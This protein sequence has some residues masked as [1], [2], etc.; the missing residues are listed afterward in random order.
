LRHKSANR[1]TQSCESAEWRRAYLSDADDKHAEEE[2]ACDPKGQ[3]VPQRAKCTSPIKADF[4]AVGENASLQ[5]CEADG[6]AQS[7]PTS[8]AKRKR[9]TYKK[10]SP[11]SLQEGDDAKRDEGFSDGISISSI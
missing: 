6:M 7:L 10:R 3:T 8:D 2:S 4:H 1:Q 11:T 9:K 5:P